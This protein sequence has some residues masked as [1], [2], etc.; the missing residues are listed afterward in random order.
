MLCRIVRK[1]G[2]GSLLWPESCS[3]IEEVPYDLVRAIEHAFRILDWHENLP[4]E[5]IPPSWM[6][7]VEHEIE[8]WF[9][10]VDR[11]REE[12]RG[13]SSSGDELPVGGMM[14]NELADEIRGR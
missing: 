8:E 12:Q 11:K 10:E 6:W 7:A 9:A 3:S 14:T 1:G 4:K 13:A 5:E 2:N